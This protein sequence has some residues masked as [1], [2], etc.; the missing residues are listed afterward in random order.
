M[1]I[2]ALTTGFWGRLLKR[3]HWP[4]RARLSTTRVV[5]MIEV[6]TPHPEV[7]LDNFWA[8]RRAK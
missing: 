8:F 3:L 4:V 5:D 1:T 2:R 6:R 7:N